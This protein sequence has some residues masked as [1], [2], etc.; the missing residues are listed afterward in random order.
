MIYYDLLRPRAICRRVSEVQYV[1]GSVV[2]GGAFCRG[3]NSSC[4]PGTVYNRWTVLKVI[5]E[6]DFLILIF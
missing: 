4:N 2:K 1:V 3:D 5:F 6:S